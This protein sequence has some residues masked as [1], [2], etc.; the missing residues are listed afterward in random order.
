MTYSILSIISVVNGSINGN[1][2]K[3]TVI[4]NLLIDSRKLSNAETSLFFAIKGERYDA[5]GFLND[6][7]AKGVRNFLV[8][9]NFAQQEPV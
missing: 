4:K 2:N 1:G 9:Q 8:N 6:L 7:Y 5:H 3:E